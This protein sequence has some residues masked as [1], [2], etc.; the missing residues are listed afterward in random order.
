MQK[1]FSRFAIVYFICTT[2]P[3]NWF[4][5]PPFTT[6]AIPFHWIL[7]KLTTICNNHLWHIKPT[8]N[9]DGGGSGDTSY[10]WAEFFTV[11]LLSLLVAF[12]WGFFDTQSRVK[13]NYWTQTL[14]RFFV[15]FQAIAYGLIK[16]FG[17]Q[18]PEPTLSR[19]ATYFG[20]LLPMRLTWS[21]IGSSYPYEFFT[22]FLELTV[23]LL[24][25]WR[26][27]ISLGVFIGLGV[28]LHVFMMNMCYDIPVKLFSFQLVI[29]C[30]YLVYLER[31]NYL[32][33]FILKRNNFENT[34][35]KP[36]L[37]SKLFKIGRVV[38]KVF[39]IMY[40][41]GGSIF[42]NLSWSN[43]EQAKA[44]LPHFKPDIYQIETYIK[45]GDTVATC[46]LNKWD[47]RDFIF[48]KGGVGSIKSI[49]SSLFRHRY[50]R[51]YFDYSLNPKNKTVEFR[52]T[53]S[54][55]QPVFTLN[56]IEND[57]TLTLKGT[58]KNNAVY[59]KLK[60]THTHF[61]LQ[62]K[63]FHWISEANR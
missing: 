18:M 7:E 11:L 54:D 13:R 41:I 62:D 40:V 10:A 46:S 33:F 51:I 32:N 52:K 5:L 59:W 1:F 37:D 49:D 61:P 44:Q 38:I 16:M 45:N 25:L 30:M 22:G 29:C 48:E 3:W 53:A 35:F 27:T 21:Y 19:Y 4:E 9:Q 43:E 14:V 31:H 20:D 17:L 60:A 50:G 47:W 39:F 34:N 24:L 2:A 6:L 23:G 28:F 42:M 56:Y 58:L 36:Y 63:P 55:P 12:L 15:C 26:R 57:S 8:L